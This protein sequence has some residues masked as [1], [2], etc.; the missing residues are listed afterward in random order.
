MSSQ[1]CATF[2]NRAVIGFKGG[3]AGV[4][5]LT[6]RHNDHIEACRDFVSSENL[7]YQAFSAIP[8][9][10]AA[11]FLRGRY[12]KPA[13]LPIV[14]QNEERAESSVKA[15]TSRVHLL[16]IGSTTDPLVS[17]KCSLGLVR[18]IPQPRRSPTATR[19]CVD[20][21]R[22]PLTSPSHR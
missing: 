20:P 3:Q 1:S 18:H 12:A 15:R 14:G 8:L 6:P 19:G 5:E 4:E 16:K 21:W 10:G 17:T 22:C 9:D 7:S 2:E 13:D 11:E